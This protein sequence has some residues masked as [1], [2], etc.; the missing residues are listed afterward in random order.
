MASLRK[1]YKN[2]NRHLLDVAVA[3][4]AATVDSGQRVLDIGAGTGHYRRH[5]APGCYIGLD[6]GYEQGHVR[7]LDV[8][9]DIRSM[10]I[11]D[12]VMDAAICVEVIEHVYETEDFLAEITRVLRPGGRLLLTSPLCF[13]EH[14]APW[15]YHRFT[16]HAYEKMAASAGLEIELL[17]PRG[18]YF[19]LLAYLVAR[20]PDELTR[21]GGRSAHLLKPIARLFCTY[22]VAPLLARLDGLDR[23]KQFTLGYVCRLRKRA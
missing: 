16:R 1:K 17:Q 23:R 7:G 10:P 12:G 9:A 18:G 5:F 3:D 22:I 14:M 20:I 19:M 21:S 2:L 15:D 4:F 8:V 6:R 11:T 13:G